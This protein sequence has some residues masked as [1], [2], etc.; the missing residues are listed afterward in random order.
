[1]I[2][3]EWK[4]F[5][6]VDGRNFSKYE[7]SSLGK[8]RNKKSGWVFSDRPNSAGYVRN[9]FLN[10]EGK[11]NHIL[12]HII[13][14]KAFL[15]EPKSDDLTVDHINRKPADNRLVN[16]RWATRKQQA[17]NSDKSNRGPKGH[18][19]IQYAMDME[20]IKTW[21]NIITA[22]KELGINGGHITQVCKGKLNHTG[23]FK[24]MYERQDLDGEVWKN[25]K[26]MDVQVS[27]MG[28]IKHPHSHITYGS[29]SGDYLKYGTPE[30]RVHVMV[31]KVF[32]PN[33]EN[34]PEVNH[35]DKNGF[36]NKLENLEWVTRREN[37]IHS[38]QTN[39]NPNRYSTSKA[40]KQYD[41]EGNFIDQYRSISQ[42]SRRTGYSEPSISRVCLGESKSLKGFIFKYA[43]ENTLN[44]PTGRCSNK[45]DLIDE[46]GNIETYESV[47]AAALD[48]ELSYN[49]IYKILC[50][51]TKKTRAG[52]H[53]KYH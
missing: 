4:N 49:S 40:V 52:Y 7:V 39:S 15:G 42:T 12:A 2:D 48:L 11:T 8:I 37:M 20:K 50:G 23:G 24:W 16:L 6:M 32:L 44:R 53:F 43:N 51:E 19:V 5:P 17:V 36:N 13:V 22:A 38:H 47:R 46:K 18:S 34:R 3:E 21:L 14:A 31:A 10:D 27:N 41:L 33:P 1:M 29:K 25:Y 30:K 28:R 26:P 9:G 45:I 35:K